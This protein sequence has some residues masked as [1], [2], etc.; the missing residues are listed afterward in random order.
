MKKRKKIWLSIVAILVLTIIV[1]IV[2]QNKKNQQPQYTTIQAEV[3][4]LS[5]T[6]S[7]TGT[8]K[9]VKELAL[10][11]LS[12][13]RISDLMIKTGDN[14]SAGQ[15]LA[16]LD[17]SALILRKNEAEAGLQIA[18]ANL[19]KLLSGASQQTIAVNQSSVNQA[20]TNQKMAQSELDKVKKT[21]TENIKQ[22]E[23]SLYD[24]MDSSAN[25]ITSQEQAIVTAQ[26]NLTNTQRTGQRNIDNSRSSGLIVFSDKILAAKIALDNIN[27]ILND[28]AAKYV[29]SVK[30]S[31]YLQKTK[32]TRDLSLEDYSAASQA[33]ALAKSTLGSDSF[34]VAA[35]KTKQ[36]L[37]RTAQALNYSYS[38]LEATITSNNFSQAKL[39]NY[40]GIISSQSNQ[41]NGAITAVESAR[42]GYYNAQM[43]NETSVLVAQDNLNQAQ[44]NLDSAQLAAQNNLVNIRLASERQISVAQSQLD[45]AIKAV[46]VAQA[47]LNNTR[48]PA[49]SADIALVQ[50][51][52]SQAQA[53]L[54]SVQKQIDDSR[55]VAP[56]DG[57]VTQVNYEIGEQFSPAGKALITVL[58]NNNFNIEVDVTESDIN[59]IKIG[60][61]AEITLD[62]F[63]PDDIFHGQ[64]YFIE[65]AQTVI[66]DVVY[67][68]VKVSFNNSQEIKEL[69]NNRQIII[70]AG[71]TANVT[72]T[73]DQRD[74]VIKVPSRAII[75]KGDGLRIVR[76]LR[77]N[78]VEDVPITVGLRGDDGLVESIGN[79]QTGEQIITFIK[80]PKNN[81]EAIE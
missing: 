56:L 66:Q 7:L 3:G 70:K 25:T 59:K 4:P 46:E 21:A 12:A 80:Y 52:I 17:Y 37:N 61:Q 76:V 41:I 33:V 81:K 22:A 62:A 71:M 64:V 42:Q 14:I 6:V 26:T 27:T 29:L 58:V 72:I 60:N 13:G 53:N 49:R 40:K 78:Q 23:K 50:G 51:Q 48:A 20:L 79:I 38:M 34:S 16:E 10:N 67:Y 55:L 73:T 2:W 19:N 28:D 32:N 74:N 68:K 24:L 63:G 44:V 77:N 30:D 43:T 45:S 11:F 18:Q 9:P 5:Q 15:L 35:D 57:M 39:D 47:Q 75:E 31:S 69:T 8:V 54:A 65:P 1:L 36:F